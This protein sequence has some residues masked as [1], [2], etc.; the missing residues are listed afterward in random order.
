MNAS[1]GHHNDDNGYAMIDRAFALIMALTPLPAMADS[2]NSP[3][4][5]RAVIDM[6]GTE[7]S[8]AV[9][10]PIPW[11]LSCPSEGT[12]QY[13]AHLSPPPQNVICLTPEQN[14]EA[15]KQGQQP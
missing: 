2:C 4:V 14:D 6:R 10:R 12:C 8:D 5:A 3:N 13:V 7:T 15:I 1:A 9:Y 11:V